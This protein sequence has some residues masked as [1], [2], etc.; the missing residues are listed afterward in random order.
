[1]EEDK[2]HTIFVPSVI[3]EYIVKTKEDHHLLGSRLHSEN[4]DSFKS[5]THDGFHEF[6]IH[7]DKLLIELHKFNEF[8]IN[9]YYVDVVPVNVKTK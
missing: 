4:I 3:I 9:S 5:D 2:Y 7:A 6:E 8:L 1:M